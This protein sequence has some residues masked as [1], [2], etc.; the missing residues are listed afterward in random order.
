MSTS[1]DYSLTLDTEHDERTQYLLHDVPDSIR[2]KLLF[3]KRGPDSFAA[4][5][6]Q[7][8]SRP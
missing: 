2:H 1:H 6:E 8:G 4:E 3:Q 7:T 5:E